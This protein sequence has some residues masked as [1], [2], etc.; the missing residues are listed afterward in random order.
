MSARAAP[1]RPTRIIR[2]TT[3]IVKRY[4]ENLLGLAVEAQT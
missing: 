1:V 3:I 4:M 2:H